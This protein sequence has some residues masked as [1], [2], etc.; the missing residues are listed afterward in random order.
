MISFKLDQP[1]WQNYFFPNLHFEYNITTRRILF[2]LFC[3]L[4]H[5]IRVA[6]FVRIHNKIDKVMC[7][8]LILKLTIVC[9]IYYSKNNFFFL[10]PSRLFVIF[11]TLHIMWFSNNSF[12]RTT[13]DE[14]WICSWKIKRKNR[15]FI[16]KIFKLNTVL[17]FWVFLLLKENFWKFRQ[18]I[19]N[20]LNAT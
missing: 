10:W 14:K 13:L 3:I 17:M 8:N 12:V 6:S 16:S 18:K 7:T 20:S 4:V 11:C 5:W 15:D 1:T 2:C 19:F 9:Y